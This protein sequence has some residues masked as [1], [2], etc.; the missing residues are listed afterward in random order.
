MS[1][2]ASVRIRLTDV[3]RGEW[4]TVG[5]YCAGLLVAL[6]A[7]R[8][9]YDS[10]RW[11]PGAVLYGAALVLLLAAWA[12][13]G[14]ALAIS[15][16]PPRAVIS[17]PLAAHPAR[18]LFV[19]PAFLFALI[20]FFELTGNRFTLAGTTAWLAALA[21]FVFAL[22][23]GTPRMLVAAL[24]ARWAALGAQDAAGGHARWVAA[25]LLGILALGAVF[26]FY[27]LDAI[28]AEMTSDHAEKILDTYDILQG[29][30]SIFFERNTGR[31]PLQFYMNALVV[32]LGIAPLDMLAL[33]V[34]GALAGVLTLPG[35]FLL[36]R[37]L[38]DDDVGL[39]AAFFF[40]ISIFPVAIARIG[41]RY[42]LSPLFVAWTL[43]FLVRALRTQRR[44][45]YLV[46]GLML[47]LGLNG[48]SPFRVVVLLVAVWMGIWLQYRFNVGARQMPAL[49]VNGLILFGAAALVFLPMLR[50]TTEHPENV[51]YRMATRLT[52]LEEPVT[53]NPL[54][55]FISNNIRAAG[56][57][58][59]QGDVVWVNAVPNVP[60]VDWA[61][62]ACF[63]VGIVYGASR[64]VRGRDYPFPLLFSALFV[65]LL[66]STLALAF[67]E[68]N[69]SVVRAGGVAPIVMIFAAL[70]LA[71]GWRQFARLR[72]ESVGMV[73]IAALLL[74]AALL[75]Y[76]LYFFRYDDQFRRAAWNSTEIAATLRQFA[77]TQNDWEHIY[78]VSAPHWV[79]YR[80]V[81]IH[82]GNYD[83][84]NQLV[85]GAAAI[86]TQAN[87]PA[88]KLYTLKNDDD[89]DLKLLQSLYPTG[90]TRVV[91]SKTPGRDFVAFYAPGR[92]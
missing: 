83:F 60:V 38:F 33:K 4:V 5:L 56:M 87:D 65:L 90:I 23:Q 25:A 54:A 12:H 8:S 62:G 40:A 1:T 55:I 27:R 63:L 64:L 58:N 68:E 92:Q 11:L 17:P 22:W 80:A 31:E 46:T 59:V 50:Y 28:P 7:Q 91:K 67:P 15:A 13:G 32:A 49:A 86:R 81:G 39:F 3:R 89:Q 85:E 42:P 45:A 69:P 61:L 10:G 78:V 79:D 21:L 72:S 6:V 29:K 41:L 52:S 70:P 19:L 2:R 26:Y 53:G 75:N 82:L 20:A 34:V 18:K 66:P 9:I 84:G 44:N 73:L 88:P 35:V 47:G 57:F 37:E 74:A 76:N 36:G 14:D 51:V 77:E 43:F 24:R 71:L 30:Y 48:Y 16:R